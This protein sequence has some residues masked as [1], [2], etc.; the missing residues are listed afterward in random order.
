MNHQ[1]QRQQQDQESLDLLRAQA[2][3]LP[4]NP[5]TYTCIREFVDSFPSPAVIKSDFKSEPVLHSPNWIPEPPYPRI[6]TKHYKKT[7]LSSL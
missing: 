5:P 2:G 3:G 1:T 7:I 6:Y 4:Y